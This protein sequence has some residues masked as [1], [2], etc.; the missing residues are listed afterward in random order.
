MLLALAPT[1]GL[2]ARAADNVAYIDPTAPDDPNQFATSATEVTGGTSELGTG[3]YVVSGPVETDGPLDVTGYANLILADD[4]DT[5]LKV[6]GTITIAD[7]AS[8]TLYGQAAGSGVLKVV[9]TVTGTESHAIKALGTGALTLNGGTVMIAA[10]NL[11]S[12]GDTYGISAVT[13]PITINGGT[14][15]VSTLAA[16]SDRY[17]YGIYSASGDV[18]IRN[19]VVEVMASGKNA[20]YAV[21]ETSSTYGIYAE[22]GNLAIGDPTVTNP[23]EGDRADTKLT[24]TAT[25]QAFSA[26]GIL[27]GNDNTSN[28][29]LANATVTVAATGAPGRLFPAALYMDS[30]GT[31]TITNSKVDATMTGIGGA[32]NQLLKGIYSNGAVTIDGSAVTAEVKIG[33]GLVSGA[34]GI[35]F[36]GSAENKITNGATVHCKATAPSTATGAYYGLYTASPMVIEGEGTTVD[37]DTAGNATTYGTYSGGGMTIR[38]GAAVTVTAT[39]TGTGTV[40]GVTSNGA[41]TIEGE[42]TGLNVTATGNGVT[43]GIYIQ[44]STA[45][46]LTI[47]DEAEVTV[48]AT[49]ANAAAYGIW[50]GSGSASAWGDIIVQG[51]AG[52]EVTA[53]N[54]S[55]AVACRAILAGGA[56]TIED[57]G[58]AVSVIAENAGGFQAIGIHGSQDGVT[59][60]RAN[61]TISSTTPGTSGSPYG[62]YADSS[63]S[64]VALDDGA[65]VTVHATSTGAYP[66]HALFLL[67]SADKGLTVSGGSSLDATATSSDGFATGIYG[68]AAIESG[69]VTAAVTG[70]NVEDTYGITGSATIT[71]GSVRFIEGSDLASY[72]TQPKNS[73]GVDVY[74]VTV[75]VVG[76]GV[77][78]AEVEALRVGGEAYGAQGVKTDD[79]GKLY[80]WLPAGETDIAIAMGGMAYRASDV[81]VE[82][83][84]TTAT[85]ATKTLTTLELA[86]TADTDTATYGV[87]Y[88]VLGLDH[89]SGR[90]VTYSVDDTDIATIIPDTGVLTILTVGEVTIYAD[91]PADGTYNASRASYTLTIEKGTNPV[92]PTLDMEALVAGD[93]PTAEVQVTGSRAGYQY[94]LAIGAGSLNEGSWKNGDGGALT[95]SGLASGTGYTLFIRLAE[96]DCY[97]AS[98]HAVTDKTITTA[99]PTVPPPPTY[100]VTL[101]GAPN[102]TGSGDY[103]AGDSVAINAGTRSGYTFTGWTVTLGGVTLLD[104]TKANTA[105][106]M[107]GNAVTLTATWQRVSAP[108]TGP[109]SDPE[110]TTVPATTTGAEPAPP[111]VGAPVPEAA[112]AIIE[113]LEVPED[114][115]PVVREDG[116]TALPGGGAITLKESEA[117][118]DVPAGTVITGTGSIEIPRGREAARITMADG[119]AIEVEPGYIIEIQPD[120]TPMASFGNPFTD[121]SEDDW[122]FEA[123]R[124][125]YTRG[126]ID[127]ISEAAFGPQLS[128]T[129]GMIVS[130]LFRQVGEPSIDAARMFSDVADDAFYVDAVAWAASNGIVVGLSEDIYAPE[131]NITREQL[132]VIVYRYLQ[133]GDAELTPARAYLP[134]SDEAEASEYALEAIARLYELGILNGKGG[135][136]FDPKGLATRGE[137][138]AI[139][140]RLTDI[141]GDMA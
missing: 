27:V 42:D 106:T 19:A 130:I 135:D 73:E 74:L 33:A 83:T 93:T 84:N 95:F 8:L 18:V 56:L 6:S 53:K 32:N 81:T 10:N 16:D 102:G 70:S 110:P 63:A 92:T 39:G 88:A 3:W 116:S 89:V 136:V 103:A 77:E 44:G 46:D 71:G 17:T 36:A 112:G 123:V 24:I 30:S 101:A 131:Q 121:V 132:A 109:D 5:E 7:G 97:N 64:M 9:S 134:F 12:T 51:G 49:A 45:R 72:Q 37:I 94:Q 108:S 104:A 52:V 31:M 113:K 85:T 107:P 115:P 60:K 139:I 120:G 35:D 138:A 141:T 80:L 98:A 25:C 50:N 119:A 122:Y 91:T 129:R 99:E 140:K 124:Y 128:T 67:W 55:E 11:G 114:T 34:H 105:F 126:C 54:N 29:T 57:T 100:A 1:V 65:S 75:S 127:G 15:D 22:G 118:I 2:R 59:I 38:D 68:S 26:Y 43:R 20:N 4:A 86:F 41:V 69:M 79:A 13:G 90:T 66:A 61:V 125:A 87:A 96:T 47:G 117:K 133:A 21:G 23:T 48:T 14:V 111:L 78:N 28:L 82:G 76:T 40:S 62:F 58:T 137:V